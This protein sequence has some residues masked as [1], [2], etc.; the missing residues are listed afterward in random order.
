MDYLPL[1]SRWLHILAAM[2]AVGGP[3]F[4]RLALFPAAESTLP[5]ELRRSLHEQLRRRWSK[6]VMVAI[7]FLLASGFYNFVLFLRLSHRWGPAWESDSPNA[8]LYQMLFGVKLVLALGVFFIAS[9]VT[10]RS[11]AFA[12]F[13]EKAKF[14]IALNLLLGVIIVCISGQ[15]RMMHIGPNVETPVV[16]GE[17]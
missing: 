3:M 9:A 5:D 16:A 15:M 17:K 13:R 6:V 4:I 8:R 11:A 10:G 7:L 2:A 14:W 1:V 12:R